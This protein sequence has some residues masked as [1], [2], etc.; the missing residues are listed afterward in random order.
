M[1]QSETADA[2]SAATAELAAQVQQMDGT[3][4]DLRAQA[5]NLATLVGTFRISENRR[6]TAPN[7]AV[8]LVGAAR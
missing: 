8:S 3:S 4:N 1:A 2:V 6:S 5:G 7:D